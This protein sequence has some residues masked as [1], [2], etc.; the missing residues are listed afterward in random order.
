MAHN[1]RNIIFELPEKPTDD[2]IHNEFKKLHRK[3]FWIHFILL[4]L[5]IG[6]YAL[7]FLYEQ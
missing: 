1:E 6:A 3:N 4:M 2:K 5:V 7:K